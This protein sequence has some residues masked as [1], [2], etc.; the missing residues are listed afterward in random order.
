M[1]R[2]LLTVMLE[3][4]DCGESHAIIS[5]ANATLCLSDARIEPW[6]IPFVEVFTKS[7]RAGDMIV[8]KIVSSE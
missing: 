4:T 3:V 5:Y 6:E 1:I 8:L 2:K 7:L